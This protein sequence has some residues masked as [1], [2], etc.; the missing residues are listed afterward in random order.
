MHYED[1]LREWGAQQLEREYPKFMDRSS[2][3]VSIEINPGFSCCGGRDPDCY[4]SFAESPSV[5]LEITGKNG[6]KRYS[7]I[8]HHIDFGELL[9]ELVAVADGTI[10]N[11]E[12]NV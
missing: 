5:Y 4:C 1:A 10:T 9:R 2:V 7:T 6:I 3:Q 12:K 8:K 11:K